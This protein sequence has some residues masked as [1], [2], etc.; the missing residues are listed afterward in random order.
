MSSNDFWVTLF[1]FQV[2]VCSDDDELT[3]NRSRRQQVDG[4]SD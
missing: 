4:E 1:S 3:L 2:V